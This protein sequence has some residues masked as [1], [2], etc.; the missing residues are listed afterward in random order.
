MSCT[1]NSSNINKTFIIEPL[2]ISGTPIVSA[3]TGVFTNLLVSCDENTQIELTGFSTTFNRDIVPFV[4][5]AIDVGI[6][7]R[8]FRDINTVS[9]TSTYWTSTVVVNTPLLDLGLDS[10]SNLRQ[11]DADNSIIQDDVL[12]GGTF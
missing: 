12:F 1:N 8:R 7:N 2:P 10:L 9:G 5:D 11:I 4:S 6:P 3:C